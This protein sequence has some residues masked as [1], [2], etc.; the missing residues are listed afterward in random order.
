MDNAGYPET[1]KAVAE[2]LN[3]RFATAFEEKQIVMTVG[4]AGPHTHGILQNRA[5]GPVLHLPDPKWS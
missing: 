3:K 1:R 4:A 5:L 2:N